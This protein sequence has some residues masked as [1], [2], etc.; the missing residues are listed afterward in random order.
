[1]R[2]WMRRS[3]VRGP[4]PASDSL[5][6]LVGPD[7]SADAVVRR[8]KRLADALRA[9]WSAVHVERATEGEAARACRAPP[10][11]FGRQLG[12]DIEV[13]PVAGCRPGYCPARRGAGTQRDASGDRPGA[14]IDVAAAVLL[15]RTPASS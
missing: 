10:V 7:S 9:P 6:A 11:G 5:V 8:A 2:D 1:M 12:A 15:G 3:G 4:W 14:F 13:R